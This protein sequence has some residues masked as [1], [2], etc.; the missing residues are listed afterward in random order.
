MKFKSIKSNFDMSPQ[1]KM[2]LHFES[3]SLAT[4]AVH[5]IVLEGI[6]QGRISAESLEELSKDMVKAIKVLRKE[7]AAEMETPK[8]LS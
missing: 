2:K 4:Q 7:I 8:I 5:Q 6:K 3:G 1:D